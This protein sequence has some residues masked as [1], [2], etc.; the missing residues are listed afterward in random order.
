MSPERYRQI[1]TILRRALTLD[2][3]E[4]AG[5]LAA[6]CGED[7]SLRQAVEARIRCDQDLGDFMEASPAERVFEVL[8]GGHAESAAGQTINRFKV[9]SLLGEG[10]EGARVYKTLDT[11]LGR[12]VAVKILPRDF[13]RDSDRQR[14]FEQE[15]C[16]ASTLSHPNVCTVYEV[17]E[18]EDGRHYIVMEYVEGETLR[19]RLSRGP[20]K[21][22]EALGLAIQ[23]ASALAAAHEKGIVH[24]DI[25]PANVMLGRDGAVKVLDFGLAKLTEP[26]AQ[27]AVVPEA[28]GAALVTT[29]PGLVMGTPA[30]MSPEQARG[31]AVDARTDVWGLGCVLYEMSAGRLPFEGETIYDVIASILRR[32]TEPPP[33]SQYS[34]ETP[35]EL[36][37]VVEKALRKDKEERYRSMQEML[38][39]LRELKG[40]LE[41]GELRAAPGVDP[42]AEGENPGRDR[43]TKLLTGA[44]K[45]LALRLILTALVMLV[46][47]A[48]AVYFGSVKSSP[49]AN[50]RTLAVLPFRPVAANSRDEALELGMAD[51]LIQRLNG[52]GEVAVRPIS[53]VQG[54]NKLERDPVEVGRE[55]AVDAVLDGSIQ[56]ADGRVRVSARL[57]RVQD[58]KTLW[59][60][61]FDEEFNGIFAIQ[62]S[63]SE[64]VANSLAPNLAGG[65]RGAL[66]KHYTDDPAAYQLFLR[67]RYFF[68]QRGSD[69]LNE[70]IVLLEQAIAKDPNFA[71][72]Y[73]AEADTYNV[74][75]SY[76]AMRPNESFPR[77][78]MA[79]LHA[80]ELDDTLAEAHAVLAKVEAHHDWDWSGAA[81]EFRR[82]FELNPNY[83]NGHYYYALNY[84]IPMGRLDEALQEMRR[85]EELDPSSAIIKTNVGLV[86]YYMRQYDR[87]IE[88]YQ[89][90][91]SLGQKNETAHLR[92]IDCYEQK[93]M[94]REA[95]EEREKIIEPKGTS[96]PVRFAL[97]KKAYDS[98]P[99]GNTYL[100][101]TFELEMQRAV[102]GD[103]YVSPTA[104]AKRAARIAEAEEA[105]RWLEKAFPERD[106]WLTR[107]GVEPQYDDIR[108]DP[109]YV[110]LLRL[111][112]GGTVPPEVKTLS[113]KLHAN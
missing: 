96:S 17:G 50:V 76:G 95:L 20:L 58:A 91:L 62:D 26:P 94:Y 93:G 89:K 2:D 59:A 31:Q 18:T 30:Y 27:S 32:D 5:Y 113:G 12:R 7:E 75:S 6:A 29:S 63:I 15:A 53:A 9:E 14:R 44:G 1:N 107:L 33:L 112:Y 55:L 47:V 86:Y 37:L 108:S 78:K 74:I 103:E 92:L 36:E 39:A 52:L 88:Q 84:L 57:V 41:G 72:A 83:A 4:R 3:G 13:L 80:I 56:R 38:L 21:L 43:L 34:S 28:A 23:V 110:E 46:L 45:N 24:R 48:A 19:Q 109:R 111:V 97:L 51:T 90:A 54:Y 40:K 100:R 79:A 64:R 10:G 101:E 61:K 42:E 81:E 99:T 49:P 82:T 68:N 66:T 71:L 16:A 87:A 105:F 102:Q 67:G 65:R 85:A 77:A 73:A 35:A 70:S 11:R 104:V 25:K 60:D 98:D 22:F 8:A 69:N 106:E